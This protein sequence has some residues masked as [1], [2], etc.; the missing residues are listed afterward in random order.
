[1]EKNFSSH[2]P[3]QPP[4]QPMG[5]Q[6]KHPP[7]WLPPVL[8]LRIEEGHTGALFPLLAKHSAIQYCPSYGAHPAGRGC[9]QGLQ[10]GA[11]GGVHQSGKNAAPR[12]FSAFT[13]NSTNNSGFTE[14]ET[15]H[16]RRDTT[17]SMPK[18][19]I[20]QWK[21]TVSQGLPGSLCV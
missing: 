12:A 11:Q 18:L 9:W 17:E 5:V 15:T 8:A 16:L 19:R 20:K 14:G 13:S 2:I 21:E 6:V 1:M 10:T 4:N 3:V 7:P